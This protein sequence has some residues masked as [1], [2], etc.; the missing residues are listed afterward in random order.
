MNKLA[1]NFE[2]EKRSVCLLEEHQKCFALLDSN[3]DLVSHLIAISDIQSKKTE[4]V[5]SGN[6]KA[7]HARLISRCSFPL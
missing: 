1:S 6:Q 5:T 2:L 7:M 4:L 3:D